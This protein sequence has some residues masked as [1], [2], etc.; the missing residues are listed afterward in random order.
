MSVKIVKVN[1]LKKYYQ[2]DNKHY[3]DSRKEAVN[4]NNLQPTVKG[5][6]K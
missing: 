2:C 1:Q 4:C 3:H 5:E 6:V